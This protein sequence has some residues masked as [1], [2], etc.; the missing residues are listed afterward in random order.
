MSCVHF[1]LSTTDIMRS[2]MKLSSMKCMF[3][4]CVLFFFH[5]LVSRCITSTITN[6]NMIGNRCRTSDLVEWT[7]WMGLVVAYSSFYDCR[8]EPW[9]REWTAM[10]VYHLTR[11]C[12]C[13][14][15]CELS[16]F[17]IAH[18]QQKK[19]KFN[20][21]CRP[22]TMMPFN[23]ATIKHQDLIL[24]TPNPLPLSAFLDYYC[25]FKQ[26]ELLHFY[27]LDQAFHVIPFSMHSTLLILE[28]KKQTNEQR[29]E[30][31]MSTKK[32]S[33][34]MSWK[35]KMVLTTIFMAANIIMLCLWSRE[36]IVW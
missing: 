14:C 10:N 24:S 20:S 27:M 36:Q 32:K 17:F 25:S 18:R 16:P 22:M 28:K 30:N 1:A 7:N 3:M 26:Y 29:T 15:L 33:R 2:M 9:L 5:S 23:A 6:E 8:F 31:K 11:C 19:A 13:C 21:C 12:C 34:A 35:N 4:L